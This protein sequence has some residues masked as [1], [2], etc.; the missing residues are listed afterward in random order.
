MAWEE[1]TLVLQVPPEDLGQNLA[2]SAGIRSMGTRHDYR[3]A[4]EVMPLPP[5]KGGRQTTPE[6]ALRFLR[7]PGDARIGHSEAWSTSGAQPQPIALGEPRGPAD[8]RRLIYPDGAQGKGR[9][10]AGSST[11]VQAVARKVPRGP[12]IRSVIIVVEGTP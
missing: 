8:G 5:P 12:R 6:P 2:S 3:W 1:A 4:A 9:T 7:Q 10:G 11:D